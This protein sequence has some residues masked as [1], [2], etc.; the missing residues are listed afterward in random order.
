MFTWLPFKIKKDKTTTFELQR[1]KYI[2][3]KAK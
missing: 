3:Y 2:K 1:K